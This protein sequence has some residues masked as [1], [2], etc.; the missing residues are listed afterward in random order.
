MKNNIKKTTYFILLIFITI[1]G[2][3][4]L[5]RP[6]LGDYIKDANPPGG[7]LKFFA[8]F[9][10]TTNDILKNAADQIYANFPSSYPFSFVE[11]ITGK[12]AKGVATFDKVIVY[13]S[14]NDFKNS[15]SFTVAFWMKQSQP[16]RATPADIGPEFYFSLVDDTYGWHHSAL[17]MLI[18]SNPDLTNATSATL[19]VG[20]MDQWFEFT[21]D[22]GRFPGI[23]DGQWHH[24]SIVY[25]ET[26]SKIT[27]YRDGDVLTTVK[28]SD[29]SNKAGGLVSKLT[30]VK[31]GDNPRGKL[32][33][34][35]ASKF[36]IGGFNKHAKID[37]PT[38]SWIQ[39]YTGTLDQFRLYGKALTAT[40]VKA[41]FTSKL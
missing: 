5:D 27:W 28:N 10:G 11:G 23:L 40:E 24:I 15:T 30:D 14:A 35:K 13:P 4:K 26:T 31:K 34:S 36:L 39:A 3:K 41:L 7:P 16:T 37:G 1:F 25:D 22:N 18:E 33:F 9:D 12:A 8:N 19:K 17:F 20:L 2:C 38:D 21:N 29:G 32:D 6:A